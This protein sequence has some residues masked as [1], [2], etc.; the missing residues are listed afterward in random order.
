[1]QILTPGYPISIKKNLYFTQELFRD[2]TFTV[3]A[4]PVGYKKQH[5]KK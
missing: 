5:M 2:N 1:M 4:T 3:K